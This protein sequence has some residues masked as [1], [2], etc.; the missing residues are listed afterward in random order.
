MSNVVGAAKPI[1]PIFRQ[2]NAPLKFVDEYVVSHS[3]SNLYG[4]FATHARFTRSEQ[5][6]H[7]PTSGMG[8]RMWM[9]TG[10]L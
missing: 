1:V 2:T 9:I 8:T 7:H 5:K 6:Y 10:V 4:S 3:F